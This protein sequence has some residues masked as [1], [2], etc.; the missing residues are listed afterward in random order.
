MKKVFIN[1]FFF[2]IYL[3]FLCR[4]MSGDAMPEEEDYFGLRRCQVKGSEN[5]RF[6]YLTGLFLAVAIW[7][8]YTS[9]ICSGK[10]DD[11]NLYPGTYH[12]E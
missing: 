3:D 8:S 6:I 7:W 4:V 9:I 1:A 12:F 2:Q 11:P 5:L 10:W